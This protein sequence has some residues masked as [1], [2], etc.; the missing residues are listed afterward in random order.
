MVFM[1][2][3]KVKAAIKSVHRVMKIAES[4]QFRRFLGAAD[5]WENK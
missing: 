2:V 3:D 5:C 1:K 4:K